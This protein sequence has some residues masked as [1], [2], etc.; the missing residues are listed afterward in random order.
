MPNS[1][2]VVLFPLL[3]SNDV[4]S[5]LPASPVPVHAAQRRF[6]P[7]SS[8]QVTPI[9]PPGP[10][11]RHFP[12]L[13]SKFPSY[14]PLLSSPLPL[15]TAQLYYEMSDL[16]AAVALPP[17]LENVSNNLR[18]PQSSHPNLTRKPQSTK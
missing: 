7:H 10:M 8:T 5:P 17:S 6:S 18:F 14:S 11:P 3:S 9:P 12:F 1:P 2:S 13:I 4:I 16:P 15:N